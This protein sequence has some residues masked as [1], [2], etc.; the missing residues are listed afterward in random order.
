[1]KDQEIEKLTN[2]LQFAT[3]QWKVACDMVDDMKAIAVVFGIVAMLA[4]LAL[5][6]VCIWLLLCQ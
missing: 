1:M 2:Q 6:G 3:S 4:C 5:A